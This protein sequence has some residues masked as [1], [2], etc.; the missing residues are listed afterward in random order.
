MKMIRTF[1]AIFVSIILIGTLSAQTQIYYTGFEVAEPT[2]SEVG[3]DNGSSVGSDF[4][5]G[6]NAFQTRSTDSRDINYHIVSDDAIAFTAGLAYK[7]TFKSRDNNL[8]SNGGIDRVVM[9]GTPTSA[10]MNA[11]AGGELLASGVQVTPSACTDYTFIYQPTVSASYHFGLSCYINYSGPTGASRGIIIDEVEILEYSCDYGGPL[12]NV[13]SCDAALLDLTSRFGTPFY[14]YN[15]STAVTGLGN[16]VCNATTDPY[17]KFTVVPTGTDLFLTFANPGSELTGDL[18]IQLWDFVYSPMGGGTCGHGYPLGGG[19][20]PV[21]GTDAFCVSNAL[22]SVAGGTTIQFTGLTP[23][24]TNYVITV[25][26]SAGELSVNTSFDMCIGDGA[27]CAVG[28]CASAVGDAYAVYAPDDGSPDVSCS[29]LAATGGASSGVGMLVTM[30][31]GATDVGAS[32]AITGYDVITSDNFSCTTTDIDL[33]DFGGNTW[34]NNGFTTGNALTNNTITIEYAAGNLG[35][36]DIVTSGNAFTYCD[37]LNMQVDAAAAGPILGSTDIC[38]DTAQFTSS[39]NGTPGYQFQ[40]VVANPVGGT[41][42]IIDDTLGTTGI[43]FTNSTVNTLRFV[44]KLVITSECC[45]PLDTVYYNTDVFALPPAPTTISPDTNCVG[46]EDT[47]YVSPSTAGFGYNWYNAAS[48]GTLYEAGDSSYIVDSTLFGDTWYYVEAVDANGCVSADRD[49][50]LLHGL[51]YTPI[52]PTVDTCITGYVPVCVDPAV[53]GATYCWYKNGAPDTLLQAGFS[54]CYDVFVDSV[55][56]SVTVYA[57]VK[58]GTCDESNVATGIVNVTS[59]ATSLYFKDF[60]GDHDWFNGDNWTDASGSV[61]SVGCIPS[62]A[63]NAFI[64]D[65][66]MCEIL[67]SGS[68]VPA[69]CKNITIRAGATLKFME[70]KSELN[71]CGNWVNLGALEMFDAAAN[72]RGIV[73]FIGSLTAQ[74]VRFRSTGTGSFFNMRVANTS[75][76]PRVYVQGGTTDDNI[77]V[78][79]ELWLDNGLLDMDNQQINTK[80]CDIQNSDPNAIRSYSANSYVVGNLRRDVSDNVTEYVFPVGN[81]PGGTYYN[82]FQLLQFQNPTGMTAS[83]MTDLTVRFDAGTA[84][85]TLGITA[86]GVGLENVLGNGSNTGTPGVYNS[87]TEDGIWTMEPDAGTASYDLALQ[88][89]YYQ[90]PDTNF[91]SIVKRDKNPYVIGTA[92]SPL[93]TAGILWGFFGSIDAP[94]GLGIQGSLAVAARTGYNGFSQVAIANGPILPLAVDLFEF[95]VMA[96]NH[97]VYLDWQTKS[98]DNNDYFIVQKRKDNTEWEDVAIIEG[99]GTV[100]TLSYYDYVDSKPYSGVS[101]YRLMVVNKKGEGYPSKVKTVMIDKDFDVSLFPNPAKENIAINIESKSESNIRINVY[102]SLGKMVY[103][104]YVTMKEGANKYDMQL[105]NF[106]TGVYH[107][108]L[109]N[110]NITHNVSFIKQ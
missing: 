84:D 50:V 29:E 37:F 71:V 88:G 9:T 49:S 103:S 53:V 46:G 27:P 40:W 28:V 20:T 78:R 72:D 68:N 102:N 41:S 4:C 15:I 60:T 2:W 86:L 38:P 47:V 35:R 100:S 58:E 89:T 19:V 34:V 45:G 21:I 23:G 69:S 61:V 92:V 96:R 11:V 106:A 43:V 6:G 99:K 3:A 75:P 44:V 13:V 109:K 57:T 12:D 7:V 54:T 98:E 31:A 66:S 59:P 80:Y 8:G 65:G 105:N 5:V 104:D 85:D 70:T 48:A 42:S 64:W 93:P 14:E 108:Q 25:S 55:G 1:T 39:D 63:T 26:S 82:S 30:D 62:C 16:N 18:E 73:N 107:L 110:D 77:V 52:I 90:E 76:D 83:G 95:D 94:S 32:V 24:T 101:Y 51:Y 79:G 56:T 67:F 81:F 91:I 22:M 17:T 74:R 87:S 33:V 97:M 10:A 36:K